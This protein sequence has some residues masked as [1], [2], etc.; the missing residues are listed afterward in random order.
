[1]STHIR[2]MPKF[3]TG[4]LGAFA[5]LFAACSDSASNINAPSAYNVSAVASTFTVLANAAVT[6]T[7]GNIT[8]EVGTFLATPSGS[9]T[10]TTCPMT[11][12]PHV[13]DS[14]ATQAFNDFLG[15][16]ATLAPKL[17]DV[18]T[19]LTGT[20]AGVTLS[21]GVYCFDAA[22][23]LTGVLTL[24]GPSDGVWNFKIGSSGTGALTGTNFSI[25]MAGDG[26]SCNVTWWVA[27]AATMTT[28]GFQGN[29][30]AGAA[31]TLTGGTFKGNAWSKADVTITGTAVS[32]C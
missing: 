5:L 4:V 25:A 18:C 12:T 2:S 11:G 20:L 26:Q 6:C 9:V 17:G 29:I 28:S 8:G 3:A 14:V 13:G 21:P 10:Q 24:D 23:T 27:D 16:Y 1:M 31:I 15:T 30:L 32:A 22:A 7:D 19:T